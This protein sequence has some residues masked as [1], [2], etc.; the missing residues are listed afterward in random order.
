MLPV[1]II[2]F[3]GLEAGVASPG[4]KAGMFVV[5]E[6]NE[7]LRDGQAIAY[8]QP[9]KQLIFLRMEFGP[10]NERRGIRRKV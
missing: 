5:I 1:D 9:E 7:R 4:L 3:E 2:G 6:G 10:W 8:R